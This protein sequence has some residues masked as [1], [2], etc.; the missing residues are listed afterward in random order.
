MSKDNEAGVSKALPLPFELMRV[1]P[2]EL[3]DIAY[4]QPR[5]G[6]NVV[7]LASC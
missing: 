1:G 6:A 2:E 3:E 4:L 5:R 7:A